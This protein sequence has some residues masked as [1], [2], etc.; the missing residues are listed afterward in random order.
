MVSWSTTRGS[1]I[2]EAIFLRKL[3]ALSSMAQDVSKVTR[4]AKAK[5]RMW[6]GKHR[7][8][9]AAQTRSNTKSEFKR[10]QG[11]V[12]SES[13]SALSLQKAIM[14]PH[15]RSILDA[16]RMLTVLDIYRGSDGE[17]RSP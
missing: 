14:V 15:G 9:P 7:L 11:R 13:L 5:F 10:R 6:V 1:T 2:S 12:R 4:V 17:R 16:D 8:Q 3:Q